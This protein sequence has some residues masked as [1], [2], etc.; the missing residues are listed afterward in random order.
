[1]TKEQT[2]EISESKLTDNSAATEDE[3]MGGAGIL[4][5]R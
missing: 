4:S 5:L 1:M 3:M 2:E